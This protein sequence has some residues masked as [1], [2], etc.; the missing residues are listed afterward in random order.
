MNEKQRRHR[1]ILELITSRPI[2]RQ[3][4]LGDALRDVGIRTTQSTLSKD[5][6]ELGVI[7]VPG[8]SGESQYQVS[9]RGRNFLKGEEL[10]QRELTDFVDSVDGAGHT[11]V[12][13]TITGHAQGVCEAI[14]QA[15]WV[16]IVGT[17][18]GENTIFLLCRTE[19]DRVILQARVQE[20]VES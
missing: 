2:G 16:E 6:R 12:V 9:G 19:Q 3:E 18:A 17:I 7:K 14:D 8:S 1:K 20:I 5:I 13:R 4:T 11:M 10:L 15:S